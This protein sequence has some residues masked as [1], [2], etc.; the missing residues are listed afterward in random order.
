PDDRLHERDRNPRRLPDERAEIAQV[1]LPGLSQCSCHAAS[2]KSASSNLRPACRRYTSSS[3]GLAIDTEATFTPDDSNGARTAGTA[4]ARWV[5]VA[6]PKPPPTET[7][8]SPRPRASAAW[9]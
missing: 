3:D 4:G 9:T 1:D 6:S 8:V 5:A 2:F 7:R